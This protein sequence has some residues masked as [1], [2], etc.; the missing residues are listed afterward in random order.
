MALKL[1]DYENACEFMDA[2][3]KWVDKVARFA[4]PI[5]LWAGKNGKPITYTQLAEEIALRHREPIV[6]RKQLYGKPAGKIGDALIGL[7]DEWGK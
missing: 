6:P 4:L 7:S 2:G 3:E 1:D 5:L